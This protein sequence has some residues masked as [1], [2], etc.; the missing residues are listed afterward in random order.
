MAVCLRVFV[1]LVVRAGFTNAARYIRSRCPLQQRENH[2]EG[3]KHDL[4]L[5]SMLQMT[6]FPMQHC[7]ITSF[8]HPFVEFLSLSEKHK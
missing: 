8:L 7:V 4:S 2:K 3:Q 1:C 6:M 5:E